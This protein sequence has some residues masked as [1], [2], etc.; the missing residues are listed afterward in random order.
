MEPP[1]LGEIR[2]KMQ[3]AMQN[4][5]RKLLTVWTF[6]I[7]FCL[8]ILVEVQTEGSNLGIPTFEVSFCQFIA[9]ML[10]QM[11]INQEV[12]GGLEMMK[13]AVNHSWKFKYPTIAFL[14]GLLQVVSHVFTGSICYVVIIQSESVLDLAKD[15]TALII[16]AEFDNQ[17]AALSREHVAREVVEDKK[18]YANL[19]MIETTSSDSAHSMGN[20][21]L[22]D[23]NDK[24]YDLVVMRN[25]HQ[26]V[27][28]KEGGKKCC[29]LNYELKKRPTNI[30]IK[31]KN[32]YKK[33]GCMNLF[34]YIIYKILRV[35]FVS[36]WFYYLPLLVMFFSTASPVYKYW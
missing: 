19:F 14:T 16:I 13:Y 10:L 32:R 18:V 1:A 31:L 22:L 6:Q 27:L 33:F 7:V 36:I 34:L 9:G 5:M 3:F 24:A 2:V 25:E 35:G 4:L 29:S 11:T 20:M 21:E 28:A 12:G 23:Q 17:F 26:K 15:F 30:S 8:T